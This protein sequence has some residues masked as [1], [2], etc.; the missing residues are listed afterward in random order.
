[1][2][3]APALVDDETLG[4]DPKTLDAPE[5]RAVAELES[6][7]ELLAEEADALRSAQDAFDR[8]AKFE[9]AGLSIVECILQEA[10]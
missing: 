1:V 3:R 9:E 6:K 7:G 5:A 4:L 8:S 10:E 2:E